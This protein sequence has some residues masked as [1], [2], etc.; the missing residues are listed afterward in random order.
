MRRVFN[1]KGKGE[2][3]VASRSAISSSLAGGF[4]VWGRRV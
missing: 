3:K 4:V 2:F 1:C